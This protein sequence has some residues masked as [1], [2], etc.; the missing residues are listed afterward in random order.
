MWFVLFISGY[1]IA[2][3]ESRISQGCSF[4][5]LG[6]TVLTCW[7]PVGHQHDKPR[8]GSICELPQRANNV[9]DM[10]KCTSRGWSKVK[11]KQHPNSNTGLS[12]SIRHKRSWLD[13]LKNAVDVVALVVR[14]F[15]DIG[16][17]FCNDRPRDTT[18]PSMDGVCPRDIIKFADKFQVNTKVTWEEYKAVDETDGYVETMVIQGKKPGH[19]F[20][21]ETNI[22]YI[23]KDKAGNLNSCSFN[24]IVKVIRCPRIPHVNDRYYHCHP[25]SDDTIYG[26]VCRFGCYGGHSLTG[27]ESEVTCTISR[28]WSGAIPKCQKHTCPVL[29]Q[30][31]SLLQFTCTNGNEFRSICTYSCPYGYGIKS[32][33]SHVRVCTQG[34]RWSGSVP[35]CIDIDPP[36]IAMCPGTVYGYA[37]RNSREGSVVWREPYATDNH[38]KII[39]ITKTGSAAPNRKI[40]EGI[41]QVTYNAVDSTGNKAVPCVVKVVMKVIKCPQIYPTPFQSIRCPSGSKYGSI[42]NIL[43]EEGS[44]LNGTDSIVCE[45]SMNEHF[46]YWTWEDNR[47]FCQVLNRCGKTPSPPKNGDLACDRWLGGQFCQMFCKN[48]YDVSPGRNFEEMLICDESGK[49]FPQNSLPLPDCSKSSLAKRG[50]YKMAVSYNFEGDCF[51]AETVPNIKNQFIKTLNSSLFEDACSL[52]TDECSIK[53]V[54]VFC[55]ETSHKRSVGMR[56]E[57]DIIFKLTNTTNETFKQAQQRFYNSLRQNQM[58]GKLDNLINTTGQM[59]AQRIQHIKIILDCPD[60]TVE[61]LRTFSCVECSP[62]TFYNH[63]SRTCPQCQKGYYQ[64]QSGQDF[65]IACPGNKTTKS[66]GSKSVTNCTDACEPGYWSPDGTPACSLCPV[67]SFSNSFGLTNCT[68]CK[69]SRSTEIEGAVD[70]SFCQEFDLWLTDRTSI[71]YTQFHTRMS[72]NLFLTSLW[73][74]K[75]NSSETFIISIKNAQ[76]ESEIEIW[77]NTNISMSTKRNLDIYAHWKQN[78]WHY[79]IL[80][81]NDTELELYIDNELIIKTYFEFQLENNNTYECNLQGKAKVS[82]LNIWSTNS[83]NLKA[84]LSDVMTNKK[85]CSLKSTGDILSWRTFENINLENTF[86][87][88]PSSC[89]DFDSCKL[90]QC[91]NGICKDTLD[92]FECKCHAGFYGETC[93]SNTDDCIGNA[94]ENNST[95]EDGILHYT[96]NCSSGFKGILCEIAM[97]N[98][99]WGS[100]N[101]WAPCSE[102]CGNGTQKRTRVCND[103]E[104]DN[105]GLECPGNST[106]FKTCIMDDCRVCGNL[107]VTDHVILTCE[108]ISDD[109]NCTIACEKGYGFD[110]TIKPF[111]LCGESTYHFW[112]YKTSDNPDGKLPQCIEEKDSEKMTFLYSASYV[113]LVCDSD[114]E[115]IDTKDIIMK[116]INVQSAHIECILNGTCTLE[117]AHV[118]KCTD[119]SKREIRNKTAGFELKFG[120]NSGIYSS[121]DCYY[122]LKD[123]LGML[124]VQTNS[125]NFSIE[126][127]G[128]TYHLSMSSAR[129]A[130]DLRC[131]TGSVSTDI[132]CVECSSGRYYRDDE[133]VKCDFGTYQ[134]ETG[135]SFCKKC[136]EGTT[137]QGR[138]S[139]SVRDCSLFLKDNTKERLIVVFAVLFTVMALGFLLMITIVIKKRLT[140]E[141]DVGKPVNSEMEMHQKYSKTDVHN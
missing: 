31:D 7:D 5:K 8:T 100:W 28:E 137:T 58:D 83:T 85:M 42:C 57:F 81:I 141:Y 108:N 49:W 74:Q 126:I 110:H 11:E 40:P 29:E 71:A 18:P 69:H 15:R 53:N 3:C 91:A 51:S 48:G 139:R 114:E 73:F 64:N 79:L 96:C 84:A 132:H 129:F 70:E 44:K 9:S 63:E 133:C 97:V 65:C 113:D 138:E 87:N 105:G 55:G 41:Y 125:N 54:Q 66:I 118:T 43:C 33:M 1:I 12:R 88:I 61:T 34:G 72:Y 62:G 136:P 2:F 92:G 67:G 77:I 95:C 99:G 119:R 14:I 56:V 94:C 116:K 115:A 50:I 123:A 47:S 25:R 60:N 4:E 103:P 24:V 102:T 6:Y 38:D 140:N 10:V 13:W 111:Y 76:N 135:K 112:D 78:G 52:Y 104:P 128:N 127:H 90:G 23:A 75:D 36:Q 134:D 22:A 130:T 26:S 45:K 120:C 35:T 89:D 59:V 107:T 131:R 32:G 27:G 39:T 17:F 30:T 109:I 122:I 98:G 19:H 37:D 86:K 68:Q 101:S 106:E 124:L 80:G 20:Q 82:Q 121:E 117:H 46:G 21:D 16:C 93:E